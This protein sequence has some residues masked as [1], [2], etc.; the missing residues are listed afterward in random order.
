MKILDSLYERVRVRSLFVLAAA[1]GALSMFIAPTPATA[2]TI[3][4]TV[5]APAK[6]TDGSLID[7]PI[8]Y[9]LEGNYD[10]QPPIQVTSDSTT[11]VLTSMP[12][13]RWC[14]RVIAIVNNVEAEPSDTAC[15]T[16]PPTSTQPPPTGKKPNPAYG[17][18]TTVSP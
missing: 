8:K 14:N 9:R 3:T 12:A 6:Y 16:V 2:G 7:A 18:A 1:L 5:K 4:T 11:F 15:A 17:I 13:G 10:G